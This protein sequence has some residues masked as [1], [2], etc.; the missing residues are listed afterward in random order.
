M[1]SNDSQSFLSIFSQFESFSCPITCSLFED[2]VI[3]VADG[4]TYERVAIIEWLKTHD[5]SPRTGVKLSS[6][7]VVPNYAMQSLISEIK[8]TLSRN[9]S[10][11]PRSSSSVPSSSS[12]FEGLGINSVHDWLLNIGIHQV[13]AEILAPSID[14]LGGLDYLCSVS[15]MNR[16]DLRGILTTINIPTQHMETIIGGIQFLAS[17]SSSS[18]PVGRGN[19]QGDSS[20]QRR[21]SLDHVSRL[22]AVAARLES[23]VSVIE[24]KLK[25]HRNTI[26]KPPLPN[27][28]F[29]IFTF[30]CCRDLVGV[31]RAVFA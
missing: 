26:R 8:A 29:P 5:T 9:A 12:I 23:L 2:P 10:A 14:H 15:K 6:K 16:S 25:P 21:P 31:N 30:A 24:P 17:I 13:D 4:H 3:T 20:S 28:K 18:A 19:S 7:A 1:T 22:E 11:I 27:I